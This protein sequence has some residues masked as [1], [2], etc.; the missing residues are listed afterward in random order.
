MTSP[1]RNHQGQPDVPCCSLCI[2]PQRHAG[3]DADGKAA[4]RTSVTVVAWATNFPC[5]PLPR[6]RFTEVCDFLH[7]ATVHRLAD[8]V[9]QY[10][11]PAPNAPYLEYAPGPLFPSPARSPG[12][13]TRQPGVTARP[14]VTFCSRHTGMLLP[15]SASQRER[16]Y[17]F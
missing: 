11:N 14:P 4:E 1:A 8:P 9:H 16:F 6:L 2:S 15:H 10:T 3:L 13:A 7:V 5:D 17:F 12:A